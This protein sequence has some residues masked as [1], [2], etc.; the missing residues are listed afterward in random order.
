MPINRLTE[1]QIRKALNLERYDLDAEF[2]AA[3]KHGLPPC[4]GVALGVDRLL[5]ILLGA[6]SIA[7]VNAFPIEPE[8]INV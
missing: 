1:L 7:E 8:I 6:T 4:S 3:M 5:M 2:M